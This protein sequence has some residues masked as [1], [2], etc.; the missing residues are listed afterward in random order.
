MS[1]LKSFDFIKGFSVD[2]MHC[3]LLGVSKL[4]IN[5][6]FDPARCRNTLH[7]LRG[8]IRWIDKCLSCTQVPSLIRRK[9]RGIS[10]LKHWKGTLCYF[11]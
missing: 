4:L 6:W 8:D 9:P 11:D 3:A 2:Y 7:D 5:L 1:C 10:D